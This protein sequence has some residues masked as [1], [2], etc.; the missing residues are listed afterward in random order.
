MKQ[1]AENILNLTCSCWSKPGEADL[2]IVS[3]APL[4]RLW[5]SMR[6]REDH[7]LYW[8]RGR[9]R[10]LG[11]WEEPGAGAESDSADASEDA[12]MHVNLE[13]IMNAHTHFHMY[14]RQSTRERIG[15]K[16]AALNTPVTENEGLVFWIQ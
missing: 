7:T 1:T 4:M 6:L 3:F 2:K 15:T 13:S 9:G 8:Q 5:L 14:P 12:N 10:S 16:V 11:L